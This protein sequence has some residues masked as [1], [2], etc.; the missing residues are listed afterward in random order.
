MHQKLRWPTTDGK[1]TV[2]G[3]TEYGSEHDELGDAYEATCS[4]LPDKPN[5]LPT[6]RPLL[7]PDIC[8]TSESHNLLPSD[9]LGVAT[10]PAWGRVQKLCKPDRLCARNLI[11]LVRYFLNRILLL[12]AKT[13]KPLVSGHWHRNLNSAS[14]GL[15]I[16]SRLTPRVSVCGGTVG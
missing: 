7:L 11:R 10:V 15:Q 16:R 13:E 6:L 8:P 5:I 12:V 2:L 14:V 1:P 4:R 9:S 3:P